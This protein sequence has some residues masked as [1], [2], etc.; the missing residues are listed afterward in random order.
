ME[1]A[2]GRLARRYALPAGSTPA[3][4][5]LLSLLAQDEHAPS[6]V[7]DPRPAVDVHL[8]DSLVALEVEEVRRARAIA[9]IGSG[10]G[11]PGLPL[12]VALADAELALVE[13]N[14]RRASFLERAVAA[15][16]ITG[17]R[18]VNARVEEWAD[19]RGACDLV[20]ARALAPLPVV[21]EYAAPLLTVGGTVVAWRGRRDLEAERMAA[22]AA[23]ELGLEPAP[24]RRVAPYPSAAH[25]YLHLMSKVSDTPA[26]FPRR[27]G[28]ALKRPLGV[29]GRQGCS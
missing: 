18:V 23:S 6:A 19:G 2:V 26:R 25:R 9:D 10:A 12:A 5:A 20:L 29:E 7:R 15:T 8:A 17:A 11:F 27:P 16:G 24:P 3:M 21:V 14:A 13:A 4:L 28:M 22:R 1:A